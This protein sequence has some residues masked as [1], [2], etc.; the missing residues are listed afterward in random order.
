[1][2]ENHIK[3]KIEKIEGKNALL[4]FDDGQTLTWPIEKLPAEVIAGSAIKIFISSE[5]LI[6]NGKNLL[7]KDILN[8]ILDIG[9]LDIGKREN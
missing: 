6:D 2:A 5:E 7:A 9:K 4:I 1:M 8:E 3:G